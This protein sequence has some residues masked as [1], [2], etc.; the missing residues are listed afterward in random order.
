Y[1]S[2]C[3]SARR[4]PRTATPGRPR[5]SSA[6]RSRSASAPRSCAASISPARARRARR[7]RRSAR[8]RSRRARSLQ[9][10]LDDLG[11]GGAPVARRLPPRVLELLR[12]E[13]ERLGRLQVAD[14]FERRRAVTPVIV[15]LAVDRLQQGERVRRAKRAE[16]GDRCGAELD[17]GKPDAEQ[18]GLD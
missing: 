2:P 14:R 1:T 7:S 11:G 13:L 17:D 18:D 4:T 9:V 15:R 16:R 10:E 6:K 3:C 12:Q 8:T 5:P